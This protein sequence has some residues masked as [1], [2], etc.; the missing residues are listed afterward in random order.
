LATIRP[1][2]VDG[3]FQSP[4]GVLGVCRVS[5]KGKDAGVVYMFQSPCGVLGVCRAVEKL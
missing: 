3:E 4:C 1:V 2:A 5:G